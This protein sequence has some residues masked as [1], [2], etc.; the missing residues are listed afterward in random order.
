LQRFPCDEIAGAILGL[1]SDVYH[2]LF[3]GSAEGVMGFI[4]E[5]WPER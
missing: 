1:E 5:H 3:Q 2:P 4:D